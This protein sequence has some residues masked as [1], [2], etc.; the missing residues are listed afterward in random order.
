MEN[1]SS[2][3]DAKSISHTS[4]LCD[5]P[6][7]EN[8]K[9]PLG[10]LNWHSPSYDIIGQQYKSLLIQHAGL[11]AKSTV[12]DIGCG[13]GRLIKPLLE[14]IEPANYRGVDICQRFVNICRERHRNIDI[15]HIDIRHEEF[16]PTGYINPESYELPFDHRQFD[17]VICLGVFNHLRLRWIMQCIRQISKVTKP[18]GILF[19]TFLFLNQHSMSKI[20]NG[21]TKRPFVF[22]IKNAD[23]WSQTADRPLLNMAHPEIPVRRALI[24]SGFMIR[25]PIR[26]G[27][28]C[29][30]EHSLT[31]HDVLIAKRG[32]G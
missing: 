12:L 24:K 2:K 11:N 20:E 31:G 23:G 6:F 7:D 17:I 3:E 13:T 32:W 10:G 9:K 18:K 21:K 1:Y 29:G 4:L 19:S 15:T 30:A 8:N 25:E 26:Y 27:E 16:N 14:V 22:S 5:L 28:W